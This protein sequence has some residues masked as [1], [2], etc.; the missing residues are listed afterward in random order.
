VVFSED[1]K[2]RLAKEE[3]VKTKNNI[4][5]MES[6]IENTDEISFAIVDKAKK[7]ESPEGDF[8][9]AWKVLLE[10]FKLFTAATK[11]MLEKQFYSN[12]LSN[13]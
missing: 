1:I 2:A 4:R 11:V 5:H 12:K 8:A 10:T 7:D 3:N 9:K 6:R 13:A